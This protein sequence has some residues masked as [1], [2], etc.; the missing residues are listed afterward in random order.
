MVWL[1]FQ[2]SSTKSRKTTTTKKRATPQQGRSFTLGEQQKLRAHY[3]LCWVWTSRGL[4][5][6]PTEPLR[7]KVQLN[8]LSGN[9]RRETTPHNSR[10]TANH[11]AQAAREEGANYIS[12]WRTC[13]TINSTFLFLLRWIRGRISERCV[14]ADQKW[15][16]V[17]GTL[18]F[19]S[20]VSG[21]RFARSRQHRLS[22]THFDSRDEKNNLWSTKHLHRPQQ[23]YD[24]PN[25]HLMLP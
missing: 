5:P 6:Q 10:K 17:F 25:T 19:H 22:L 3:R 11:S 8:L 13:S 24:W 12:I 20:E 15:R 2:Q 18:L 23:P 7:N 1:V 14:W 16:G 4:T 9:Q 21:T